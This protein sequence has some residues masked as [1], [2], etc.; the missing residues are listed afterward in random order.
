MNLKEFIN[1]IKEYG[2]YVALC[3]WLICFTKWF[4]KAKRIQLTYRKNK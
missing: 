1:E 4:T 2:L 3:N